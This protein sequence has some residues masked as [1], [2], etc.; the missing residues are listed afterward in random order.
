MKRILAGGLVLAA[1]GWLAFPVHA[2]STLDALDQELKEVKQQHDDATA[3]NLANFFSQVDQAM[4]SADAAADLWQQAGGTMPTPTPVTTK[5]DNET[6]TEREARL[7]KDKT[8]AE[9]LGTV[10]QLHCGLLHYAAIFV[11]DPKRS[12]LKDEFNAWLQ[13]AAQVY[14]QLN[15]LAAAPP[16]PDPDANGG[17]QRHHKHEA[18]PAPPA[19][20]FDLAAIKGKTLKDS[21]ISTFLGF[22]SWGD[23]DQ[24]SWAVHSIPELF[25]SNILDPARV[26]PSQTTLD[27][28]DVYIAMMQADESD[29]AKWA[30]DDYPPL[31]FERA[32][33]AYAITP[34][35]DSLEV[36]V[37]LIHANPTHPNADEWL[38]RT[39]ALMDAYRAGH[40]GAPPAVVQNTAPPTTAN[41]S[42]IIVTT[43]QQGDA[44]IITT[45]TNAPPVHP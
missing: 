28:W 40:G 36:L 10:L 18:A 7:A 21:V 15:A 13:R 23:S 37:Q 33:D 14:P 17:D 27:A 45:H 38:K 41:N 25:K 35:V 34:G 19:P 24:G 11:T 20:P 22:K 9:A 5:Y 43:Q 1:W 42:G 16:S 32:Y 6:A 44:Q 3:Q 2:Q 8:N 30:S 31:Q 39:R 4:G 12:G 26:R 29:P